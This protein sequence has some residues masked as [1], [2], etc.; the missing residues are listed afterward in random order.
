MARRRRFG[1]GPD[2]RFVLAVQPE[3][4]TPCPGDSRVAQGDTVVTQ[5]ER[6]G[7]LLCQRDHRQEFV[8]LGDV[9]SGGFQEV[10]SVVVDKAD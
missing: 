4:T 5:T 3:V 7:E 9:V 8:V 10:L 2:L 6:R 1:A